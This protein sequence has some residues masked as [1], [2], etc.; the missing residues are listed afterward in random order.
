MNIKQELRDFLREENYKDT[1]LNNFY[2][3]ELKKI[4]EKILVSEASMRGSLNLW[5]VVPVH[6]A[7]IEPH[8][9]KIKTNNIEKLNDEFKKYNIKFHYSNDIQGLYDKSK[10][11]IN[12]YFPKN[13]DFNTLEALIG[14]EMVHKEQHK[15]AGQNY[16]KQSEKIV[17]RINDLA[18]DINLL[19]MMDEKDV[20]KYKVL[21]SERNKLLNNFLY[22]SPYESMAYAY[23]FVKE[24]KN[25]LPQEIIEKLKDNKI[26]INNLT[27]I[28]IAM[29]WLIRSKI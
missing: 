4:E 23:Q 13:I 12:I 20:K 7:V 18:K 10:D 29:Y 28:Y 11:E 9:I 17:K 3:I 14:H 5:G 24:Y 19:D 1:E 21:N 6:E 25:L 8:L 15:N 2:N 27:K 26:L 22:L 16:F